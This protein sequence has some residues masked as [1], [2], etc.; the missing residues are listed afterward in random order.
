MPSYVLKTRFPAGLT[1]H[2]VILSEFENVAIVLVSP[3]LLVRVAAHAAQ[4]A[5]VVGGSDWHLV[6]SL[7]SKN[8]GL[9][10]AAMSVG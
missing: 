3:A 10:P 2:L 7:S 4:S 1:K 8:C 6:R 9:V 5:S